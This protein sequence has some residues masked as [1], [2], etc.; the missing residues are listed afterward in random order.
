MTAMKLLKESL[1]C[2]NVHCQVLFLA[3]EVCEKALKAGM[4]AL[5]G[6]NPSSLKTHELVSHA[7]AISSQK[8]DEWTQLPQL[9]SPMEHYYLDA[10]FPNRQT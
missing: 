7:N 5:V 3:H 10:R 8:G 9:V 1:P 2:Y 4:Y 6:L